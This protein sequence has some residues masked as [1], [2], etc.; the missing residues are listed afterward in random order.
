M[1]LPAA[2]L[3]LTALVTTVVVHAA[4]AVW[5][6][7]EAYGVATPPPF[8]WAGSLATSGIITALVLVAGLVVQRL[9]GGTVG[10]AASD[11]VV[12]APPAR[13]GMRPTSTATVEETVIV[14]ARRRVTST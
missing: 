4:F 3:G 1:N 11:E 12:T 2:L 10:D 5:W 8:D 7:V 9:A 14:P 6:M 13:P